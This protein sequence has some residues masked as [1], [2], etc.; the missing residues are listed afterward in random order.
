MKLKTA[1]V[2]VF[3][4][5][6]VAASWW[7]RQG[8][9][10]VSETVN[11]AVNSVL[12]SPT[13]SVPSVTP[14][15]GAQHFRVESV[16]G[17]LEV[18]WAVVFTS[19]NRILVTERPGRIRVIENGQLLSRPLKTFSDVVARGEAGLMGIVLDPNYQS[20]KYLYVCYT[21]QGQGGLQNKVVRL[22]DN[23]DTLINES[24]I[25]GNTP[26]A[27][28]HAGCEL[29]FGPDSKL[30]IS[31][32]DA[33]E[34]NLAQDLSS[35]AGKILR[36]EPSGE[37]PAD[38]PFDNSAVYSYG[39]RNVQGL[40]WHPET[41]Q[42]WITDHGPSGFDGPQGGDEINL[43]MPGGNYGWP[44]VSH[45]R[46]AETMI[47]PEH[48]FTPAVAPASALF[49][50]GEVFPQ[51]RSTLLFAGLRGTGIFQVSINEDRDGVAKVEKLSEIEVGRVREIVE[52]LDGLIYFT[53]S[54]R[55]GRGQVRQG[56]DHL[57]RLVPT[58]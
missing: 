47:D 19:P 30:Y 37:I 45:D 12:F 49:Y 54:N 15:Q 58:E 40:A 32:G 18:P 5:V 35:L 20:N 57:Y 55:D 25:L 44:V 1:L 10:P 16:V 8:Q 33:S 29:S 38:N 4:L 36:I 13:N 42:L 39:H 41:E 46:S 27:Q 50:Q 56:D 28:F 34:R 3:L 22:T 43:I 9:T 24:I 21:Y 7:W 53:T 31:A 52:G 11:R 6:V 48:V 23:G 26:T 17:G 2:L 51:F 14:A